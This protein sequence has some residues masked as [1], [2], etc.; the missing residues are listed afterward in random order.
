LRD[1]T[2]REELE[3]WLYESE[4][5]F[6]LAADAARMMVY[7]IDANSDAMIIVQG[8][9]NL[10]GYFPEEISQTV[11]WWSKQVHPDDLEKIRQFRKLGSI[12]EDDSV[13]YRIRHKNGNYI[14]VE[15]FCRTLSGDKEN[16]RM[17]GGVRDITRRVSAEKELKDQ[18]ALMSSILENLPVSVIVAL[19]PSGKIIKDN[20]K[21]RTFLPKLLSADNIESY[22]VYKFFQENG[23]LYKNVDLPLSRSIMRGEA[24]NSEKLFIELDNDKHLTVEVN[25]APILDQKNNIMAAVAIFNDIT[26]KE[27][28]KEELEIYAEHLEEVLEERTRALKDAE[29]LSAIGQTAGMVG[30]DIRNPLQSIVSSIFLIESELNTLPDKKKSNVQEELTAIKEQIT[31]VDKIVSDLQDYARPLMPLMEKAELTNLIAETLSKIAIPS[32]VQVEMLLDKPVELNLDPLYFK[33]IIVNLLTNAIQAMPFGGTLTVQSFMKDD[34][35][36]VA[37]K[38]TGQGIPEEIRSKIFTPL[39]T[40]KSKGQGFGLAVVKRLVEAL[41]GN[42]TFES[43]TNKGTTFTIDFPINL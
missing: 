28:L 15:D 19:S 31:Y 18:E 2:G 30:H 14:S 26:E 1:I 37:V 34:K 16:I 10:L 6:K 21:A 12:P 29:R 38:D 24:V 33:R 11:D 20:K 4:Q 3:K 13:S 43:Q 23:L 42:I 40:T 5:R 25:S 22:G 9:S 36:V 39:F 7:E 41:D 35:A 27:Q 32:N 8:L 17:V